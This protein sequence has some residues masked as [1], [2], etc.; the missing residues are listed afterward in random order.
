MPIARPSRPLALSM[1]LN[2]RASL[3]AP[4]CA[5]A[6]SFSFLFRL[7]SSTS[8]VTRSLWLSAGAQLHFT[9]TPLPLPRPSPRSCSTFL[10]RLFQLL[11]P[12]PLP[13]PHP[14][15]TS[16]SLALLRRA[17]PTA[18]ARL[19]RALPSRAC[20]SCSTRFCACLLVRASSV[21]PARPAAPTS[22]STPGLE[23]RFRVGPSPRKNQEFKIARRCSIPKKK[24]VGPQK[25]KIARP[26]NQDFKMTDPFFPPR[27]PAAG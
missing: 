7:S 16:C 25:T 3:P 8:S 14:P 21:T 18:T 24:V 9:H 27:R 15:P 19:Q 4:P 23:P 22:L 6:C 5:G 17:S 1:R 13:R 10:P 2:P 20:F 11:L 12:L 26:E